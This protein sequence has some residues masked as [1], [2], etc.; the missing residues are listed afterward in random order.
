MIVRI[1]LFTYIIGSSISWSLLRADDQPIPR[2]EEYLKKTDLIGFLKEAKV[3]LKK[4]PASIEAPRLALDYLM[5]A[6]AAR[7]FNSVNEATTMLLFN[8]S[9]SL[10]CLYF[11]SSFDKN[12]KAFTDLLVAKANTG[13][14]ASK[15]YAVAY[16]RA[17]LLGARSIGAQV[18][19]DS[20][21]R[22]R[23]YLL[24]QK[25]EVDEM[26]S[27]AGKALNLESEKNN[28]FAKVAKIVIS[29]KSNIDKIS[30]LSAFSGKDAEFATAFYL[31]QLS[32]EEKNAVPIII[33]QLRQALF[34]KPKNIEQAIKSIAS[35]PPTI[36]E[37]P[38][39]QTFL[40]LAQYMDNKSELAIQTLSKVS[41]K[42]NDQ[43]MS[44][45]EK[46]AKSL[47][48]GIKFKENRTKAVLKAIG[49]AMDQMSGQDSLFVKIKVEDKNNKNVPPLLAQ[50]GISIEK[51]HLEIHIERDNKPIFSY[52]TLNGK[53]DLYS[54][55]LDKSI[56]FKTPGVF[57]VPRFD[58]QRDV[59]TGG[60]AYNFNLNFSTS[61]DKLVEEGSR[62][63][64]SPYLGTSK[65]REVFL[66]YLLSEKG[67]W[68][69][70]AKNTSGGTSYPL[71]MINPEN[72]TPTPVIVTVDLAKRLKY[73]QLGQFTMSE[74]VQGDSTILS[75]LP[76]WPDG[77]MTEEEKFNFPLFMEL[78]QKLMGTSK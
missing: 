14:L 4:Y 33:V 65:G 27:S 76:D 35:L 15:E 31:A 2:Y 57:P 47:A 48:D 53:S 61:Q 24:G 67:L 72:P 44:E 70:P 36:A 20:S 16:C 11:V 62:L 40:G 71:S 75:N 32:V 10:P 60:F 9:R 69:S 5:V 52:R 7:D 23:A 58:V 49:D 12:P 54:S 51:E 21:L 25:A 22:L 43:V 30:A 56:S 41:S 45:W 26:E 78:I 73:L 38:D 74:L 8:Y 42:S 17:L 6:K 28:G 68:I 1:L 63:L 77:E 64:D 66:N 46:T 55:E 3:Y 50:I 13:N 29:E 39:V 59:E 18:L 19:A 37:Q 34:G